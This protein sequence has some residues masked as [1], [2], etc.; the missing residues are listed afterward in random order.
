MRG[1]EGVGGQEDRGGV[2]AEGDA[3]PEFKTREE[4]AED[5]RRTG[6]GRGGE[7]RGGEGRGAL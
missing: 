1:G 2:E 6:Q 4:K 3:R 5:E 7:G